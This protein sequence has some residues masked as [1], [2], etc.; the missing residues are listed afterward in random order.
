MTHLKNPVIHWFNYYYKCFTMY[1]KL[2]LKIHSYWFDYYYLTMYIKHVKLQFEINH[3]HCIKIKFNVL[4]WKSE[5]DKNIIG[6]RNLNVTLSNI[7]ILFFFHRSNIRISKLDGVVLEFQYSFNIRL[8]Q[9]WNLTETYELCNGFIYL[10][11]AKSF[12][13]ITPLVSVATTNAAT[14]LPRSL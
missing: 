12:K 4:M 10:F 6:C 8:G 2:Q 7:E 3:N 14:A 13:T 9:Y 5:F 11:H 1:I